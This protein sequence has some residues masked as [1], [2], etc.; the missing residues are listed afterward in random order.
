MIKIDFHRVGVRKEISKL[1]NECNDSQDV[2]RY[3]YAVGNIYK[4]ISSV[5]KKFD[6]KKMVLKIVA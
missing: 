4:V 2:N 3:Q 1:L 5:K 6:D